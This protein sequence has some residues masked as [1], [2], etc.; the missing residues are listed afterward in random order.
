M[1][2]HPWDEAKLIMV[3]DF[4]DML[5]DSICYYFIEKFYIDVHLGDWPVV[6]FFRCVLV[7]FWDECNIGIIE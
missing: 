3:N 6:L 1:L 4:S 2:N 7:R 5:L